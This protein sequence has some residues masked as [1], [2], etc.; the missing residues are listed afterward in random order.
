MDQPEREVTLHDYFHIVKK[1]K[2]TFIVPCMVLILF[3]FCLTFSMPSIYEVEGNLLIEKQPDRMGQDDP[4]ILIKYVEKARSPAL[5]ERVLRDLDLKIPPSTI[6]ANLGINVDRGGS[7]LRIVL[8]G[9]DKKTIHKFLVGEGDPTDNYAV[10]AGSTKA[11]FVKR[12]E[13]L[14]EDVSKG[15]HEARESFIR[16]QFEVNQ[17]RLEEIEMQIASFQQVHRLISVPDELAGAKSRLDSAQSE[18]LQLKYDRENLENTLGELRKKLGSIGKVG[19][20]GSIS[21]EVVKQL[22]QELT[23]LEIEAITLAQSYRDDHPK[24]LE[25]KDKIA[26]LQKRLGEETAKVYSSGA[27]QDDALVNVSVTEL[28]RQE[29]QLLSLKAR[30]VFL[31]SQLTR[32]QRDFE[33]YLAQRK[34][35]AGWLRE[36]RTLEQSQNIL[37]EKINQVRIDKESVK[38]NLRL[39]SISG[40]PQYPVQPNVKMYLL[41]TAVVSILVSLVMVFLAEQLDTSLK[42][43]EEAKRTLGLQM[44]GMIPDLGNCDQYSPKARDPLDA[45]LCTVLYPTST[46]AEAFRTLRTTLLHSH[47]DNPFQ[48]LLITSATERVGKSTVIA[49]TAIVLAQAGFQVI[50]VDTDLRRPAQHKYFRVDNSKGLTNLLT[51]MSFPEVVKDTPVPR[52]RLITS[53]PLPPNPAELLQTDGFSDVVN[54]LKTQADFVLFDNPP[55]NAVTD[56]L[57]LAT[58]VQRVLYL[59]AIGQASRKEVEKGLEFLS[60]LHCELMGMVCNWV[61][62]HEMGGYYYHYSVR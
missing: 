4:N 14:A 26:F 49:N 54:F 45:K 22:R 19:V 61:K 20:D 1:R 48:T 30:E 33:A 39:L 9:A 36:Q 38:G 23:K 32:A 21:G 47:K 10:P 16:R 12:V 41:L 59:V 53:G 51:G 52:L 11:G 18:L 2:V 42:T 57:I 55:I 34:E 7:V 58:K 25:I 44:R 62:P 43:T 17:K 50:L 29:N 56:G 31:N 40:M 3:G 8:Q 24:C 27:K 15:S 60:G 28:V 35:V 37:V 5:I 46:E 13:A 6:L